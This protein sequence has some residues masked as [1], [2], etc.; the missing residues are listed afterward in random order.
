MKKFSM[1]IDKQQSK[2]QKKSRGFSVIQDN[3]KHKV[4]EETLKLYFFMWRGKIGFLNFGVTR[5]IYAFVTKQG[6]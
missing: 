4:L 2:K 1:L 6:Q 5:S 3:Y